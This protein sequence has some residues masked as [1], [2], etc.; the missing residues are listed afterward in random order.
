[1]KRRIAITCALL[2]LILGIKSCHSRFNGEQTV[3]VTDVDHVGEAKCVWSGHQPFDINLGKFRARIYITPFYT[4]PPHYR[5]DALVQYYSDEQLDLDSIKFDLAVT[6]G[7]GHV[8]E[9]P[10]IPQSPPPHVKIENGMFRSWSQDFRVSGDIANLT[11]EQISLV[12]SMDY[13]DAKGKIKH[14]SV[15]VPL[16]K[17]VVVIPISLVNFERAGPTDPIATGWLN[18]LKDDNRTASASTAASLRRTTKFD[19]VSEIRSQSPLRVG[20]LDSPSSV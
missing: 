14:L 15:K 5:M 20:T 2:A 19:P 8:R 7:N 1:M 11:N 18:V 17:V 12:W 4:E 3:F 10:L 6:D 16:R 13:R 9:I